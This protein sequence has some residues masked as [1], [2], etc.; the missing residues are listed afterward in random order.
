MILAPLNTVYVWISLAA[1]IVRTD[2][3]KNVILSCT[4]INNCMFGV[5]INL[6][7]ACLKLFARDQTSYSPDHSWPNSLFS[8]IP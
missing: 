3:N 8:P 2:I 1:V 4:Y 5:T 6:H 7:E